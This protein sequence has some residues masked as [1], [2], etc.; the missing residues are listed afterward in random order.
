M[1]PTPEE[2]KQIARQFP[3]EVISRNNIDHIDEIC[4][5]NVIDHHDTFGETRGR[6][7]LKETTE[8]LHAVLAGP[9]A[10]VEDIVVEENRVALRWNS[11]G[12]HEGEFLGFEPTGRSYVIEVTMF[13]R[14]KDGKIAER[15]VLG[16]TLGML[17]QFGI[18]ELPNE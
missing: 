1:T 9:S 3:E 17:Q 8:Y 15:W 7:A 11:R 14:M 2:N 6:E 5:E 4:T 10:T 16:D 12:I 18:I 13:A